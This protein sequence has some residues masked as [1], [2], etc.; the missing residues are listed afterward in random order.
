MALKSI[1][2]LLVAA[3]TALLLISS[4]NVMAQHEEPA[5]GENHETAKKEGF[6]AKEVIFD[7]IMYA[8]E[9]HFVNY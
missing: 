2:S 5:T 7:H 8:H 4:G 6:D 1:K 9:L 3:F